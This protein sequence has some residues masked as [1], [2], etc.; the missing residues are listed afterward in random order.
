MFP[1]G[2]WWHCQ[3]TLCEE[4]EIHL[5]ASQ[6]ERAY[7]ASIHAIYSE[8]DEQRKRELTSMLQILQCNLTEEQ[9]QKLIDCAVEFH[10]AF[11]FDDG[12][13]G[14]VRTCH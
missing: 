6:L 14:E 13:R 3:S 2:M 4:S 12:E 10:A 7:A 9:A 5:Q 11:A 1:L 8:S